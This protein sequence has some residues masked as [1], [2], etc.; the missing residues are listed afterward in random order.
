VRRHCPAEL[1]ASLA[2]KV[3]ARQLPGPQL[4]MGADEL[5]RLPAARWAAGYISERREQGVHAGN[6]GAYGAQGPV[7]VY[8]EGIPVARCAVEHL[9]PRAR[10][11]PRSIQIRATNSRVA[12]FIYVPT[13]RECAP[14]SVLYLRT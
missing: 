11:C 5:Q 14:A 8:R 1:Q 9:K 4:P 13:G 10:R 3:L 6:D 2:V 7:G 12:D